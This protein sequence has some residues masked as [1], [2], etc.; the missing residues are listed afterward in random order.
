[1][2]LL[3]ERKL[4]VVSRDLENLS[5]CAHSLE[6]FLYPL[7]WLRTF[8]PITPE[9]IDSMLF[10]DPTPAIYGLHAN[11]FEKLKPE[12]LGEAVV[13]FVDQGRVLSYDN[14][15]LPDKVMK[16]LMSRLKYFQKNGEGMKRNSEKLLKEDT[17]RAFLDAV[18]LIIGNYRD[19][20]LPDANNKFKISD[21][22]FFKEKGV[23]GRSPDNC[24]FH[25]FRK[26]QAFEEVRSSF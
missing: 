5:S 15:K 4:L 9:Y 11:I 13:L 17:M 8:V 18:L 22:A 19:Y 20:I 24:F 16:L 2:A 23:E 26:T 10:E 21:E 6:R 3:L 12:A 1:M 7:E 25:S 14:I